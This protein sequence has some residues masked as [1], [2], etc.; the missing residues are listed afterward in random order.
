[1]WQQSQNPLSH[2]QEEGNAYREAAAAEDVKARKESAE[3][4][5]DD[6]A[7]AGTTAA[8][9]SLYSGF[10]IGDLDRWLHALCK[11]LSRK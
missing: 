7:Y 3:A 6:H 11:E 10:H 2:S 8:K 9:A 5:K 1:M 4:L